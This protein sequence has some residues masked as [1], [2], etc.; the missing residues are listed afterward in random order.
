[1]WA[2]RAASVFD[3]SRIA[4]R[5]TVIVD[6]DRIA[7]VGADVP[8]SMHVVDLPGSTVLPGL[9]DIHQ[10]LCFNGDGTL[11]EQVAPFSDADLAERARRNAR[12]A[13][14]G[15]VTTVRDLGDRGFVSLDLRNDPDLP[16]IVAA[17]PP[18]T[19]PGGHC[20][21]LGGECDGD[22]A[23]LAAVDER[24]A[25]G[26]DVVKIMVTGGALT[27]T[28]PL[29]KSQFSVGQVR[30][31]VERAHAAGLSVAAHCHGVAG[32]ADAVAAGVDT[33]EH[34]SFFTD[35]SEAHPAED[36]LAALAASDVT[37]SATLGSLPGRVYPPMWAQAVGTIRAAFGRIHDLGGSVV[38][39]TD[40]GI[41]P[42]KPHDVMPYALADLIDC[43]LSPLAALAAMTSAPATAVGLRDRGRLVPGAAADLI[44]VRGDP[45]AD[46][47]ALVDVTHV[48]RA[49][50]PVRRSSEPMP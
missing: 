46:P 23:L 20:W 29:W 13:L 41:G 47:A 18:V 37:V 21:Y 31:M 17:G 1:M 10:H 48:W 40:A 34:C 12:R 14:E 42:F 5:P 38:G 35:A 33:I 24:V 26:C 2:I 8:E 28:Y 39:S 15:G 19:L 7:A 9:V 32:I 30:M 4:E 27:P 43:G 49:G 11:E 25:N 50:A 45:L 36:L 44:A 16:H 6:D 3:G 22:A